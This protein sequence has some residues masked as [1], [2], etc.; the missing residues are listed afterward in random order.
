[1]EARQDI[2]IQ[3]D[4]MKEWKLNGRQI[5][6]ILRMAQCVAF[7]KG[8]SRAAMR[9]KH[10]QMMVDQALNFEE[11]FEEGYKEARSQLRVVGT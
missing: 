6:N 3:L 2:M 11:Y 10:T 9:F 1:M 7:T 8:R 5:R 4:V